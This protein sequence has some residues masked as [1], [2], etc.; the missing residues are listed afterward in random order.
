[1]GNI[2][3][4]DRK[5]RLNENEVESSN[6]IENTVQTQKEEEA[7]AESGLVSPSK[8]PANIE[9][10]FNERIGD[11]YTAH[12]FYRNAANWCRNANY[13]KAAA[14]FEAEAN[15]ELD[16]AKGLQDYL[17]QW[18]LIPA[19]PAA[20]S[21]QKFEGLVDI[22]NNAYKLEYALFGKYSKDQQAILAEHPATFNFIQ[23]Y[24]D[25]QN[26]AVGEYSDLL[27]ALQLVNIESKLD[28]LVFEDKYFA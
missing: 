13:K 12:Y 14:F 23:K 1:M 20:P 8:L 19:I 7:P 11:E 9:D 3:K 10:T 15:S 25:I 4:F 27:N 18:N 21:N 24:V 22:I 6:E 28:V 5:F 17:T 2:K 26:D 16:H